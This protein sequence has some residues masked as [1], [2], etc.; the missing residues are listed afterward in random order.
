[1]VIFFRVASLGRPIFHLRLLVLQ[2]PGDPL[3]GVDVDVDGAK[4]PAARVA[5][6]GDPPDLLAPSAWTNHWSP[7]GELLDLYGGYIIYIHIYI[8]IYICIYIHIHMYKYIYVYIYLHIYIHIYIYT[9][10]LLLLLLLLLLLY[11]YNY[12]YYI[13]NS[14]W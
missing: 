8:Y 2:I 1:M 5:R 11:I 9:Y 10:I 4:G 7:L 6:Q 3:H 14:W 13:D 12:I